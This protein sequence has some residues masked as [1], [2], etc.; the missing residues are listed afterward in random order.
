MDNLSLNDHFINTF[1]QG[2]ENCIHNANDSTVNLLTT[3]STDCLVSND[4]QHLTTLVPAPKVM[5]TQK[6]AAS[7]IPDD[8]PY[9]IIV[10]QPKTHGFRFRY[11]CEGRSAGSIPGEKS[12]NEKKSYPTIKI[13]NYKGPAVVIVSCVTKDDPPK[14]HPHSL[15]GK[16]CKKGVCTVKCSVSDTISFQNL[17]I[18]CVK[19]KE[20]ADALKTRQE[21]NVDPFKT[22]FDHAHNLN[23]DFSVIRLCFQTFIQDAQ[24]QYRIPLNAVVSQPIIDKKTQNE[25]SIVRMDKCSGRACG[26]D[27]VFLLCEKV[28]K[29]NIKVRFFEEDSTWEAHGEFNPSDVHHQYAIVFKTPPYRNIRITKDVTV[30]LQLVRPS[31]FAY[32][33]PIK[34]TYQPE[35][36]DPDRIEEKRKRKVHTACATDAQTI[37]KN[38]LKNRLR[39]RAIRGG[40]SE[41]MPHIS[42]YDMKLEDPSNLNCVMPSNPIQHEVPTFPP[43]DL[44]PIE[45]TFDNSNTILKALELS[46]AEDIGFLSED[47]FSKYLSDLSSTNN[48][49]PNITETHDIPLESLQFYQE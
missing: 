49:F 25:L 19:K 45:S 3:F 6:P 27:E 29:D 9:V 12:T 22:G 43:T 18:Q 39:L 37:S 40:K 33:N 4:D 46:H 2:Q 23:I 5:P 8:K 13:C 30:L 38:D 28:A 35:D 31:D 24:G 36:P 44:F 15:V 32:S 16:D 26:R 21:I 11:Q 1:I 20:V 47:T 48:T 17:G 14:P 41:L 7:V 42:N 34:F 10:D